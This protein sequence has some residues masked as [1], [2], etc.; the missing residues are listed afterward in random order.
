MRKKS[1]MVAAA[2]LAAFGGG[3]LVAN[4]QITGAEGIWAYADEMLLILGGIGVFVAV[5]KAL[6]AHKRYKHA[7]DHWIYN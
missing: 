4:E 5:E 1:L 3:G 6:Q 2:I 7:E